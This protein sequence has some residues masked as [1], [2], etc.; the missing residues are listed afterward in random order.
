MQLGGGG[1]GYIVT[2]AWGKAG[3]RRVIER[4]YRST[5]MHGALQ[6]RWVL[7]TTAVAGPD[8][9]LH[10]VVHMCLSELSWRE[11]SCAEAA[12]RLQACSK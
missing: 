10:C 5:C 2:L 6:P 12:T 9:Q 1:G 3:L 7:C 8:A 11:K 4:S